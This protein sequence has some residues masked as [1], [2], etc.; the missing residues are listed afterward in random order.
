MED[1]DTK[2][3]IDIFLQAFLQINPSKEGTF[4]RKMLS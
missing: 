1:S 3:D 2:P 4:S